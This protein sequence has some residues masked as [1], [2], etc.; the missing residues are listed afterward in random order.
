ML[1]D[2]AL[3]SPGWRHSSIRQSPSPQRA[4]WH[5]QSTCYKRSFCPLK[6]AFPPDA[7]SA[8]PEGKTPIS[9]PGT[10]QQKRGTITRESAWLFWELFPVC[11]CSPLHLQQP[12]PL[13]GLP[14]PNVSPVWGGKE[15]SNNCFSRCQGIPTHSLEPKQPPCDTEPNYSP[16]HY[17]LSHIQASHLRLVCAQYEKRWAGLI[18]FLPPAQTSD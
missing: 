4:L 8:A 14:L 11:Q 15:V 6:A 16:L 17:N 3:G 13:G 18:Q 9:D 5:L 10:Q 7:W 1:P 2:T 12:N